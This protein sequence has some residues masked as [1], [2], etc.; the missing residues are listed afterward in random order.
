MVSAHAELTSS[1][2]SSGSVVPVPPNAVVLTFTEGV[3]PAFRAIRLTDSSGKPI[4]L[5][6]VTQTADDTITVAINAALD[7]GTY[8]VAWRVASD[9]S[10]LLSGAFAFS[11]GA[12]EAT[13]PQLVQDALAAANAGA[14]NDVWIDLGRLLSYAGLAASI[15]GLVA[16]AICAPAALSS[17]R[18]AVALW[19][20]VGVVVAGTTLMGA[21]QSE[22]LEGSWTNWGAVLDTPSGR[23]WAL[24][25]VGALLFG[26]VITRRRRLLTSPGARWRAGLGAI[27][28]LL[29]TA[30]AGHAISG[31]SVRIGLLATVLHLAAMAMWVG[32]LSMLVLVVPRRTFWPAAGRFSPLALASVAVLAVTGTVN[33]WRQTGGVNQLLSTTYGRT[34]L[35]KL[36]VVMA[37]LAV[38]G[39]S[40][41]VLGR[42]APAHEAGDGDGDGTTTS[43]PRTLRRAVTVEAVGALVILAITSILAGSPPPVTATAANRSTTTSVSVLQ[44]GYAATIELEPPVTGGATINVTITEPGGGFNC[45]C[46]DRVA[47]T[48]SLPGSDAPPSEFPTT[49]LAPNQFSSADINLSVPGTW[50]ITASATWAD[51]R[52]IDF[53]GRFDVRLP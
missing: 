48:A 51:G 6:E 31:R 11:V 18:A 35:I 34:L 5:G 44:D 43:A 28:L 3:T 23:W 29:V 12:V 38:A 25:I 52:R 2:P 24:R 20:G 15:G 9:D 32:G 4:E 30:A 42:G 26:V 17:R 8:V 19:T 41:S 1:T 50:E 46:A 21:A 10:H 39:I 37:V 40:R 36:A 45:E 33:A 47:I 27:A 22:G 49:V 13:P 7:D 14:P 16:L 53:T